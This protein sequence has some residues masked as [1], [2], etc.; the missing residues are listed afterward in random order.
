MLD[1]PPTGWQR[2][3][4]TG[5]TSE[6]MASTLWRRGATSWRTATTCWEGSCNDGELRGRGFLPDD[7]LFTGVDR[8]VSLQVMFLKLRRLI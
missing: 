3:I 4:Q 2:Q 6:R 7:L 1:V 5:A 8:Q